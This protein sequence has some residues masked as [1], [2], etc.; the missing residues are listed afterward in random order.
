MFSESDDAQIAAF[1][2][3]HPLATLVSIEGGQP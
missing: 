3:A 2:A 1:I